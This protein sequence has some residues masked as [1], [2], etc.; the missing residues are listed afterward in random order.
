[1]TDGDSQ[2]VGKMYWRLRVMHELIVGFGS[3]EC[4]SPYK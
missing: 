2:M 4:L 3:S 1:M